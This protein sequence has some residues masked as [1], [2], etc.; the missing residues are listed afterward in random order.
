MIP[1]IKPIRNSASPPGHLFGDDSSCSPAINTPDQ[2]IDAIHTGARTEVFRYGMP[3]QTPK[4]VYPGHENDGLRM[5][6]LGLTE[7]LAN[8]VRCR[9]HV[10][11]HQGNV[12]PAPV[13]M[14]HH[15]LV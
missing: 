7:W 11:V 3:L 2:D 15:R 8:T 14:E 4:Q 5:A 12:Q 1:E 9:N 6:D 10:S 13:A